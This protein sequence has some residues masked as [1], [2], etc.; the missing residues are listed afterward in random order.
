MSVFDATVPFSVE[1]L[2]WRVPIVSPTRSSSVGFGLFV[3]SSVKVVVV[4]FVITAPS[5]PFS[6]AAFTFQ[7][8]R[9]SFQ[10]GEISLNM[11]PAKRD[12]EMPPSE[13]STV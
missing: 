13:M 9:L 11:T 1:P 6:A 10:L 12:T 7:L 8:S 5:K 3:L 2:A 4:W